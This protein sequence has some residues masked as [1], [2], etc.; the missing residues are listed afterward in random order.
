MKK[1]VIKRRKRVPAV[2]AQPASTTPNKSN[3]ATAEN[4]PAN[5][6]I[7]IPPVPT[8][9]TAN[10]PP[11]TLPDRGPFTNARLPNGLNPDPLGIRPAP[12]T[13]K[14]AVP[15]SLGPNID[16]RKPWWIND[17][18]HDAALKS[19]E[20]LEKEARDRRAQQ[21]GRERE[22]VS[23]VSQRSSLV[24]RERCSA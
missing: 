19:R 21:E 4:S 2:G 5:P 11:H 13:A 20:E 8:T 15:L 9:A 3:P 17:D 7:A 1:T 16:R 18:R 22:G 10:P 6:P 23:N 24:P 12:V 14:P